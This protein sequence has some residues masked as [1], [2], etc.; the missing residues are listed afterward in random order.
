MVV[1]WGGG[2]VVVVGATV[3]VVGRGVVVVV[4]GARACTAVV[5]VVDAGGG[6]VVD[7]EVDMVLPEAEWAPEPHA[8]SAKNDTSAIPDSAAVLR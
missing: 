3:V 1:V 2:D 5:A 6:R 7:V 8:A 4:A